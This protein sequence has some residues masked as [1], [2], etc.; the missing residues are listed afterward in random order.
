MKKRKKTPNKYLRTNF[1]GGSVYVDEAQYQ[2]VA[3]TIYLTVN[4]LKRNTI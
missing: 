2:S 1:L 4:K 3:I